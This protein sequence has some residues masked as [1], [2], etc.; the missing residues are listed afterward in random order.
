MTSSAAPHVVVVGGGIA[1]LAT[2]Y[3]L[4]RHNAR[5]TLLE[6]KDRVGGNIRTDRID[7]FLL[8]AGPDAF[9]RTKPEG[10]TLCKELGLEDQLITPRARNV[11]VAHRGRLELMPA[12]MALAVPTRL[13]PLVKTPLLSWRGKLRALGEVLVATRESTEDESIG[14]FFRRRF[15]GETTERLAGPLLGGIYAGEVDDLSLQATFPQL[16]ELERAHGSLISGLFAAQQQ[17]NG[18]APQTRSKTRV[19]IE[20]FRW[21]RRKAVEAPSP[22]YSLRGGMQQ[23]TDAIAQTLPPGTIRTS[24][25][26]RAVMPNPEM[27]SGWVVRLSSGETLAADRV[28]LCVPAYTAAQL[29]A[30]NVASELLRQIPYVSTATVFLGFTRD[31]VEHPLDGV[32]FII[33]KGESSLMAATWVSSKWEGRAPDGHVL[34]RAFVGGSRDS[35]RVG[36]STDDR[37][38]SLTLEELTR[39]M[40]PLGTPVLARVYRYSNANPQPLVGHAERLQALRREL[41]LLPGLELVGAGYGGVGIPDC[42]KQGREAAEKLLDGC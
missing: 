39:V 42:V 37:L 27:A 24:S 36:E 4:H 3:A 2:A 26:A 5:V 9:L 8:D 32:G 13:G 41:S 23:L 19:L 17:R 30:R 28:A 38:I 1:G 18:A 25:T 12:G 29:L 16:L 10:T 33:P 22:F 34:M 31:A 20:V 11:Y 21:L 6:S 40:G 35:A 7:G 15:G 14:H